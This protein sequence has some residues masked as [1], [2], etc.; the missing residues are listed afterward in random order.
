MRRG[1][2]GVA[3]EQVE[4]ESQKCVLDSVYAKYGLP[5][6]SDSTTVMTNSNQ[7]IHRNGSHPSSSGFQDYNAANSR[8]ASGHSISERQIEQPFP[9]AKPLAASTGTRNAI[10]VSSGYQ[11]RA[12]GHQ[13]VPS[14]S[15]STNRQPGNNFDVSI[16][17][18][19]KQEIDVLRKEARE[20]DER[21]E[22]LF[23]EIT[24]LREQRETA[25]REHKRTAQNTLDLKGENRLLKAETVRE[26]NNA[27]L[28]MQE[29]ESEKRC[30]QEDFAAKDARCK[31]LGNLLD[32]AVAKNHDLT[33]SA[34]RERQERIRFESQVAAVSDQMES[35]RGSH[36]A[37]LQV[38][39]EA[40]QA[41]ATSKM[42]L[43]ACDPQG[44]HK[45]LPKFDGE[46]SSP[47]RTTVGQVKSGPHSE[48]SSFRQSSSNVPSSSVPLPVLVSHNH[49]TPVY[50][51]V[52]S[53][54]QNAPPVPAPLRLEY[55]NVGNPIDTPVSPAGSM[56]TVLPYNDSNAMFR[57]S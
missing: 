45:F 20:K 35:L 46:P 22:V 21:I 30:L 38:H 27:D 4:W 3:D 29:L 57:H 13:E 23:A 18:G 48:G 32:Q 6:T 55:I 19:L 44:M 53:R 41:Y 36:D 52:G 54:Q 2:A 16:L 51:R 56:G 11:P 50:D 10:A 39:T 5:P 12:T 15:R 43:E 37:L 42:A 1:Q 33:T 8:N 26:N 24:E 31:H 9:K 17:S 47:G 34:E 25:L 14:T 7:E 40:L 49:H 28:R